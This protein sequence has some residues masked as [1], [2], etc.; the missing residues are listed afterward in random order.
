M[1]A[2]D[3][4]RPWRVVQLRLDRQ[5]R[6][7][8]RRPHR[9]VAAAP[10]RR[11]SDRDDA[12]PR[13]GGSRDRAQPP[14][15]ERRRDRLVVPDG[16]AH[17]TGADTTD[18]PVAAGLAQN[19]GQPRVD[20][21][22]GSGSDPH[23]AED[24]ANDPRP[25]VE[26]SPSAMGSSRRSLANGR[27]NRPSRHEGR[28]HRG[29]VVVRHQGTLRRADDRQPGAPRQPAGRPARAPVLGV[30]AARLRRR[31]VHP[32]SVRVRDPGPDR[33]A[34]HV[35]QP[36]PVPPE[37]PGARGRSVRARRGAARHRRLGGL[38]DVA[39]GQPV[40]GL[41][42]HR[43]V[44]HLPVRRDRAVRRRA[45]PDDR[46]CRAPGHPGQVQRRLRRH[47]AA[48]APA[49]RLG[50]PG[51]ARGRRPVRDL[52]PAGVPRVGPRSS[53][54]STTGRSRTSGR[55]S[56]AGRPCRRTATASC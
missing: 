19:R 53:A 9:S 33:A 14:H 34:R 7:A 45:V 20:R 40:P 56:A 18:Q 25:D 15:R 24:A 55:T 50:R 37:L 23:G 3:R 27:D 44:P 42:R 5:R 43:Q 35:A 21:D 29:P 48:D 54:T 41:A 8:E 22:R 52:L 38:L 26:R 32:V 28:S 6:E 10:D 49:R 4:V 1:V 36:H 12:R 39:R 13:P 16:G 31:S 2:A 46:R 11:R 17:P 47:G 30:P 51:H